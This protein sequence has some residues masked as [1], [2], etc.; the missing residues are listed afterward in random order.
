MRI[1]VDLLGPQPDPGEQLHDTVAAVRA[2]VPL[3]VAK[4]LADDL[5]RVMR[6]LSE[7]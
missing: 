4:R 5:A 1:A 2:A 3:I 6:G 7:A